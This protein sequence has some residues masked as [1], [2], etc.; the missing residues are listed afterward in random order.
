M[1]SLYLNLMTNTT[2][3]HG[4]NTNRPYHGN[5]IYI[6]NDLEY[7][8][9]YMGSSGD[10]FECSLDCEIS[11]IFSIQDKNHQQLL[12]KA[13]GQDQFKMVYHLNEEIDW[14]EVSR[15]S[16]PDYDDLEVFLKDQ[17]FKGIFFK[18]RTN[19]QS[20]LI[21]DQKNVKLLSKIK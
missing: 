12:I 17:G 19:I 9:L 13:F 4:R 20:I 14:A 2:Y 21:F 15:L 5:Q 1:K 18:E 3:Y 16:S 8:K 6:T 11:E 10:L 7:A